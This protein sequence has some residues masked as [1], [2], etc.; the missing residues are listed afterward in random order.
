[1][2]QMKII[3]SEEIGFHEGLEKELSTYFEKQYTKMA[4][5]WLNK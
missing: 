1:M 5:F 3:G 4:R 2:K